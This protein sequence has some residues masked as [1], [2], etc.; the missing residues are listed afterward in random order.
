MLVHFL[1]GEGRFA[2][3]HLRL[4]LADAE[5]RALFVDFHDG[6]VEHG[7]IGPRLLDHD[8][9]LF[10]GCFFRGAVFLVRLLNDIFGSWLK[11]VLFVLVIF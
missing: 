2:R 11:V 3:L 4:H 10:V 7:V 5:F 1:G 9:L 8:G 6:C